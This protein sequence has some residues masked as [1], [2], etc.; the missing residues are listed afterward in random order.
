MTAVGVDWG[1]GGWVAICLPDDGPPWGVFAESLESIDEGVPDAEGFAVDI[2]I[3]LPSE[4]QERR[5]ADKAAKEFVGPRHNSVFYTPIRAALEAPT[6]R[7]ASRISKERT[8]N[9]ISQ[10]AYALS[11]QI[12]EAAVWSQAT[13]A[14]VWEV[15]PEV[16]YTAL[17][18]APAESPK[19]TWAGLRERLDG[20]RSAGIRLDALGEAGENAGPDDIAD[21]A[22]AAWSARRLIRG[23]G[24][25]LPADPP[26]DPRTGR[27]VAI[28]A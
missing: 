28:W 2:P 5:A 13:P 26:H 7:E 21:A 15:H 14:D 23:E 17:L 3:G 18:G 22:V 6:H 1:N 27:P 16:S 12:F 11:D 10:Q 25:S 8:D 4:E 9:G 20:L 24:F 19:K